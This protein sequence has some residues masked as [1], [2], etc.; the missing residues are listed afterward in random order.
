MAFEDLIPTEQVRSVHDIDLD[1]LQQLGIRLLL[2]D[3]DN[4]LAPWRGDE[5]P[6]TLMDWYKEVVERGFSLCIV[7]NGADTR[8]Q[9]FAE[10]LGSVAYGNARKPKPE[11]FLNAMR[12]FGVRPAE[13]AMIGDQLLTDI[14]GGNRCGLHTILVLPV[15]PREWWGTRINRGI[16][17]VLLRT[18]LRRKWKKEEFIDG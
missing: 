8:V 16:E 10:R 17:W 5:V 9:K 15:H 4:T 7:S 14:R 2:S 11:A 6:R 18:A 13:T 3:L 1:K 12:Q